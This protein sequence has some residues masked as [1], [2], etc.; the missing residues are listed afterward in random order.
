MIYT[1]FSPSEGKRPGGSDA[2]LDA[3]SL[4]FGLDAR[5]TMLD[6]YNSVVTKD[7]LT[8]ALALFGLKKAADATPYLDNVY[9]SPTM[10]VLY[11]YD[12]VAYDYLD[13]PSLDADAIDYLGET[14][15][16]FSNLFGPL[17]AQD[18]IP[19]YK[20]KQGNTVGGIAPE[21]YYKEAFNEALDTLIGDNDILDLRA[22]YYDKFYKPAKTVTTMKFIKGGKVVSHWAKAYR[23]I[24]ARHLA[25]HRFDTVDAL[26]A[27]NIPGLALI[28]VMEKKNKK[29]VVFDIIT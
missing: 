24:V 20:V 7:D 23:G 12:G 18:L 21:R 6:A 11:R 26:L 22:G 14:L 16:I 8:D 13:V 5:R 17:R 10:P 2:P 9:A 27:S 25:Q 19:N 4:L 3:H 28:E 1:L 15:I 29:E